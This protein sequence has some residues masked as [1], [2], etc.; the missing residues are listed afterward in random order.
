MRFFTREKDQ[1]ACWVREKMDIFE[2]GRGEKGNYVRKCAPPPKRYCTRARTCRQAA[3]Y[4]YF[5]TVVLCMQG[6]PVYLAV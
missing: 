3:S 4:F 1:N 5:T 2:E 6:S